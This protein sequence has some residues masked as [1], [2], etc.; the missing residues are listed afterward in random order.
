MITLRI[1]S[2]VIGYALGLFPTGY[3]F[4]KAN[5]I[6]IREHGSGN[7]GMTNALRTLGLKAGAITFIG[8]AGKAIIA[9]LIIYLAFRESQPGMVKDLQLY[10]GLGAVLGHNF[11]FYFKFKGGKGIACTAGVLI[12]F[13]PPMI[14]VCIGLFF[15]IV[16]I[17]RYVSVGSMAILIS[18]FVQLIIYGQLGFFH[19]EYDSLLIEMYILGAIFMILGIARHKANIIRL[20]NGTENKFSL[21]KKDKGE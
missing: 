17:T 14:P 7:V 13:F 19:V 9:I 15:V 21:H 8:D 16:I 18:F 4:G 3:I 11:P 2:I 10:A 5:H 1:I 6:D 20:K 12:A